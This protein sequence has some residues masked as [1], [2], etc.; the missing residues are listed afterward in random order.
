MAMSIQRISGPTR[1]RRTETY[2]RSCCPI[3]SEEQK[4]VEGSRNL[5]IVAN[6]ILDICKRQNCKI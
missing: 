2:L 5:G 3:Y 4:E 1:C 6:N